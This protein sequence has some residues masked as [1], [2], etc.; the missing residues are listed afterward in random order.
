MQLN[1]GI[2]KILGLF[3]IITVAGM[4]VLI[5][6]SIFD[7]LR[8]VIGQWH[9]NYT[10]KHRFDKPP[11]AKCYCKDCKWHSAKNNKCSNVTWADRCTP[12]NGFCY[13]ASP[14]TAEEAKK[15]GQ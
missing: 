8:S 4:V 3:G 10:Y 6:Y 5:I 7:A 2:W 14:M 15:H 12:D 1:D 11:T 9:W 13:D